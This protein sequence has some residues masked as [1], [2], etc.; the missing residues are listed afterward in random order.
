VATTVSARGKIILLGEHGVVYGRP[1]LA[2]ALDRGVAATGELAERAQLDIE[3]WGVHVER[4]ASEPRRAPGAESL[5]RAFG[6]LL[7][8]YG[9]PTPAVHVRADVALPGGAGLGCS[10]AL[11]VAVLRAIDEALGH[12]R[13]DDETAQASLAWERVFHGNPSGVDS[14]MAACGGVAVFTKGEPLERVR[15]RRPLVVVVGDSEEP[16]ATKSMVESVAR[17]RERAPERIDKTFD[18]MTALVRN[19][20]LAVEHGDVAELGKLMDL[21]QALLNALMVSTARLEEMCAAAR[22]AGARGAKLTGAGGGGCMIAL[23]DDRTIAERV[24]RE[25]ISL[26]RG[27]FVTEVG[28]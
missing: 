6:A 16:S 8:G 25:L 18:G 20:R 15:V 7:D 1:A 17:Q 12:A 19:G 21:N 26:G 11:G 2:A 27:A 10:A 9:E 5:A 13:T 28:A 24:R 14:T 3:P 4:G 23:V 22:A